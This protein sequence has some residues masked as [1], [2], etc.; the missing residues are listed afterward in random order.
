MSDDRSGAW[1]QPEQGIPGMA[2]ILEIAGGLNGLISLMQPTFDAIER[3]G[4]ARRPVRPSARGHRGRSRA[5]D[6]TAHRAAPATA[7]PGLRAQPRPVT[8]W[9]ALQ[10][11]GWPVDLQRP[12][13]GQ[14]LHTY[15]QHDVLFL[16]MDMSPDF[17]T[18]AL[19]G[20]AGLHLTECGEQETRLTS[21]SLYAW[22][23]QLTAWFRWGFVGQRRVPATVGKLADPPRLVAKP[24]TAGCAPRGPPKGSLMSP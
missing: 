6:V 12:Y 18:M 22:G 20:Y 24:L 2:G 13:G 8:E 17:E 10:T 4:R 21:P 5:E 3:C 11:L 7:R 23:F 14:L 1:P 19:D 16:P 9:A 15:A